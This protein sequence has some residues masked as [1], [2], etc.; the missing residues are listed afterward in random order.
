MALPWP[1]STSSS[2]FRSGAGAISQP[3]SEGFHRPKRD[4]DQKMV[5]L[6]SIIEIFHPHIPRCGFEAWFKLEQQS[7]FRKKWRFHGLHSFWISPSWLGIGWD[8][9]RAPPI[10]PQS[11][12]GQLPGDP[13]VYLVWLHYTGSCP[14]ILTIILQYIY[15]HM[16]IYIYC[17]TNLRTGTNRNVLLWDVM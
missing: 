1:R 5:V 6:P 14:M 11:G 13:D 12:P 17:N 2:S 16:Y 8:L 7:D 9:L 4:F 3:K 10:R 15:I